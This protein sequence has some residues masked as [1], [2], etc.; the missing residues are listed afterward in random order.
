MLG[1]GVIDGRQRGEVATPDR[2]LR[3]EVLIDPAPRILIVSHY[4]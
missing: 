1:Y 2:I 4:I 3:V